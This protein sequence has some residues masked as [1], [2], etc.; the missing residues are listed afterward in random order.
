MTFH[1]YPAKMEPLIKE[2]TTTGWQVLWSGEPGP[3]KVRKVLALVDDEG[4]VVLEPLDEWVDTTVVDDTK[5]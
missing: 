1:Y 4:M 5:P 3:A 2:G